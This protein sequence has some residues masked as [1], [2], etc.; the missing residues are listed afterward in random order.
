MGQQK[1]TMTNRFIPAESLAYVGTGN[2]SL[3]RVIGSFSCLTRLSMSAMDRA[4]SRIIAVIVNEWRTQFSSYFRLRFHISTNGLSRPLDEFQ[5]RHFHVMFVK[6][7]APLNRE[8]DL[9]N[10]LPM[11][12]IGGSHPD[13]PI[14]QFTHFNCIPNRIV[15]HASTSR[16]SHSKIYVMDFTLLYF[17][18]R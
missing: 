7:S 13:Q 9:L 6:Q 2:R 8:Y 5:V 3:S 16:T 18:T 10:C 15:D 14:I 12:Q 17:S 1:K 4:D 11:V